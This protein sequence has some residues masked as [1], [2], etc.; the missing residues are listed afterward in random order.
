MHIIRQFTPNW[1]TVTMGTGIFSLLLGQTPGPAWLALAGAALWQANIAL[2]AL[3]TL[4][5]TARWAFYPREAARIFTHPV[6]PMFLGAIPMGLATIING[7]VLYGHSAQTA[8]LLWYVD[9]ALS[10][11]IGLAVPFAMVIRQAH[12]LEQMTAVWL[13]PIVAA[14]VAAASGAQ[15]APHLPGPVAFNLLLGGYALWAFS[16]P[17]ALSVL[18][19]LFLRLVLHKLPHQDMAVSGWLAVGPLGTGALALLLLG[20]DA[21]AIL[22]PL[23]MAD[24]GVAAHGLG[25]I[26]G[27]ML[28]AYG[29]WWLIM[30][31]GM[32]LT[33]LPRRLPFNMG[34]WGF[35][36]PLGVFTASTFALGAQTGL[37]IFTWLAVAQTG[38]LGVLWLMVSLRT[39][40]GALSGKLFHA[41]CIAHQPEAPHKL[42]HAQ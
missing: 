36:F 39:L 23:G 15:I 19:I 35:T 5:Y 26:G 11:A 18:V 1:F 14:E 31:A 10:V 29:A 16:M 30:A 28:W 27:L 33:Y 41:P 6:M 37:G 4:L 17:L 9:A 2:F 8:L 24:I 3:F 42:A 20:H 22:A 38:A 40:Y 7:T 12:K 25:L 32:T 34:W 13:L 21:P